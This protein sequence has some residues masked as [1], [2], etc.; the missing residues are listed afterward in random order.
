MEQLQKPAQD[1]VDIRNVVI[2]DG[3]P[4]PERIRSYIRQV[5]NP[6][7]FKVGNITVQLSYADCGYSLNDRFA[8]LISTM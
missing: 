7:R 4:R 8:D 6:Y 2:D 5:G 3:L 1:L